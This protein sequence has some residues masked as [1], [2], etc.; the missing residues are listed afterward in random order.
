MASD[1]IA[2]DVLWQKSGSL[3]TPISSKRMNAFE[4][5]LG[6]TEHYRTQRLTPATSKSRDDEGTE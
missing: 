5:G 4:T 2:E 6:R 3:T 1:P